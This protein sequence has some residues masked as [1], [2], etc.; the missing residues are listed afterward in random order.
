MTPTSPRTTSTSS[1]P[2]RPLSVHLWRPIARSPGPISR[3]SPSADPETR[4]M[5]VEVDL[6]DPER[7]IPVGTTGEVD[8]RR[9]RAD[10][11][12]RRSRSMPRRSRGSKAAIFVVDGDVAHKKTFQSLGEHGSTLFLATCTQAGHA[13]RHRR[14]RAPVR[15]RP[16]RAEGG[17]RS[18]RR[19]RPA[20]AAEGRQPVTG[21]ALRNPIAI[22]MICVGAR[23]LRRRRHAAHERRHVPRAHAAGA[24]HRHARPR[25]RREGRR[26]D[27]QLAP[28]EVRE[29]DA[30]RRS[31]REP[32]A[33]QLQRHLRVAQ[34]GHRPQRR[35]D[36]GAVAG[37]VRDGGGA[38]VARRLAAVRPPIRSRRTRPSAR[39]S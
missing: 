23:R 9:R 31:R 2:A 26:E 8:D 1:P 3:R 19:P 21:L 30:G 24:H 18:A 10:A 11:G 34:V 32:L 25:P 38:E 13:G 36:A 20:S 12:D 28:R 4:T 37:G 5:H 39:S 22:L 17:A 16:R 14:A 15:R 35:A 27:A 33:Q 7:E 6:P 29:R